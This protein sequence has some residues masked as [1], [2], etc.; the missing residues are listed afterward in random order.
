MLVWSSRFPSR[1]RLLARV[2]PVVVA[3]GALIVWAAGA[4]RQREVRVR[5][6]RLMQ[7]ARAIAGGEEELRQGMSVPPEAGG[8]APVGGQA[9]FLHRAR[10]RI[11]GSTLTVTDAGGIIV[12]R[13]PVSPDWRVGDVV[14]DA[15]LL[16]AVRTRDHGLIEGGSRPA[17]AVYAFA[18][19]A[20]AAGRKDVV[21]TV[22]MPRRLVFAEVDRARRRL[23]IAVA[24][25]A[26][27]LSAAWW[28]GRRSL[29]PQ[30][31]FAWAG[32]AAGGTAAAASPPA[33]RPVPGRERGQAEI[34]QTIVDHIPVMIAFIDDRGR[35]RWVN[36]EW[37]RVLGWSLEEA[38]SRDIL[39]EM[40]PDPDVRR[41]VMAFAMAGSGEW[42]D[43]HTHTKNG[44]PIETTWANV[45][46]SDGTCIGLGINTTALKRAEASLRHLSAQLL[47]SQDEERRRIARELH[48][49]TAQNLA[50]LLLKLK[51]LGTPIAALGGD[52]PDILADCWAL[53]EQCSNELRTVTYLLH[54]PLL[55]ELGLAGAV[56]EYV[57]GFA[58]RSGL[59]A[60]LEIA[61]DL[62]R[63]SRASELTLF[64]VL[65]EALSNAH[66]H[67]G[68]P[69]V[70]I[71]LLRTAAE[72]RLEVRDA[73]RG[74]GAP[75]D[76]PPAAQ[77]RVG[78]G[79][80]GMRERLRHL[81]G[82]LEIASSERG[83]R[84]TA[85]LPSAGDE[86]A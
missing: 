85:V 84:I 28:L 22:G 33:P 66:R 19:A 60:D 38:T 46:L 73:G 6:Q 53:A 43:F 29:L 71:R 9:R 61:S 86:R 23:L 80:A 34:L 1:A 14:P 45:W 49:T 31:L 7:L 24:A 68:S 2:L 5:E 18:A 52:A 3:A 42:E 47:R 11:P 54:P 58:R 48:D 72:V 26:A 37:Q 41:E 76:A 10:N 35:T 27:L 82:R 44:E 50:A 70:S 83:T 65:Q 62:G 69:T 40:Y 4:D 51:R 12:A 67:S 79:I 25:S 30:P 36:R 39:R 57:D 13:D 63:S 56:R 20:N 81:G 55:D 17:P 15:A 32:W 21:T 75:S 16:Q 59:R 78:V 74:L 64:R 77:G 8:P